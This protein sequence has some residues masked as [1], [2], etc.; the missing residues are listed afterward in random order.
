MSDA[1]PGLGYA[2]DRKLLGDMWTMELGDGGALL[3]R[4][5]GIESHARRW[6]SSGSCSQGLLVACGWNETGP[7]NDCLLLDRRKNGGWVHFDSAT[8]KPSPR[9]WAASHVIGDCLVVSGGYND[10]GK[11]P[12]LDDSYAFDVRAGNWRPLAWTMSPRCRH[13]LD[14]SWLI[15]GYGAVKGVIERS[16]LRLDPTHPLDNPL[17]P[18]ANVPFE[19]HRAGHAVVDDLIVAGFQGP[20]NQLT[21]STAQLFIGAD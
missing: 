11:A 17:E 3:R 14:D 1:S 7:L 8:C 19:A 18:V 21:A 16:I 6:A 15:G 10:S 4:I 2:S 9:R 13:T 20:N 12:N 5:D